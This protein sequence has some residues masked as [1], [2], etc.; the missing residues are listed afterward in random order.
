MTAWSRG[1]FL[2]RETKMAKS[3]GIRKYGDTILRE[4]SEVVK[5]FGPAL[6]PLF[7]RMEETMI[8]ERGVGL[9]GP[10]VG[11]PRQIAI[12]NP[13]P[14]DGTKLIKMVN[15]R[16]VEASRETEKI[17]EGCLSVPGV[18]GDVVRPSKI[19]VEYQDESGA[20]RTLEAEGFLARIIQHELDHL[21]G[22]LFVD[23]LSFA[24][25]S[26]IKSKLKDLAGGGK[27]K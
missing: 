9:A 25:R 16:I 6:V 1:R 3:L 11:V 21:N 14:D 7:E 15:P 19:T 22:V 10:Q 4:K 20:V 17:E 8:V 23:R 24:K 26:L 2:A 18:R 12:V 5:E 27:E 13:D